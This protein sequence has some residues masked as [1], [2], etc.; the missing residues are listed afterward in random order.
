[1]LT[2]NN[3]TAEFNPDEN[4]LTVTQGTRV[5]AILCEACTHDAGALMIAVRRDPLNGN[6]NYQQMSPLEGRKTLSGR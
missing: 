5:A 1:M 2:C 4:T 3:C 6:F